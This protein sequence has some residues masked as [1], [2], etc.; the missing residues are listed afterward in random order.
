MAKP[1]LSL[2][3]ACHSFSLRAACGWEI[4]DAL[5]EGGKT[6]KLHIFALNFVYCSTASL[7]VVFFFPVLFTRYQILLRC[8]LYKQA[9]WCTEVLMN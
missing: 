1:V 9:S 8:R 2:F 4:T 3:P 5:L 7:Y 6:V